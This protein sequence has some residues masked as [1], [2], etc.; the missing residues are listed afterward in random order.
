M[1]AVRLPK[2]PVLT[3]GDFWSAQDEGSGKYA[4]LL[5][6][7]QF[8]LLDTEGAVRVKRVNDAGA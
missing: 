8:G 7:V 4:V 6:A 2:I 3:I 1:G 5:Q